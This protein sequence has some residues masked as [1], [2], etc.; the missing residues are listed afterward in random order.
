VYCNGTD[1]DVS[2][3]STTDWDKIQEEEMEKVAGYGY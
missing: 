2:D 1:A 3:S